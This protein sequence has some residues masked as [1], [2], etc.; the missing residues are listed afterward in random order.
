MIITRGLASN[1][2]VLRGYS[3]TISIIVP[4]QPTSFTFGG[5]FA[6]APRKV[7]RTET[8]VPIMLDETDDEELVAVFVISEL[9]RTGFI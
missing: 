9:I 8:L 3:D 4:D 2:I 5:G 1:K 6:I 7:S